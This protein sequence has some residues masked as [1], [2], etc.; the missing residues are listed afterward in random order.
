MQ[1]SLSPSRYDTDLKKAAFFDEL[2]RRVELV[3]G[4]RSAAVTM[5]LP[6]GG[7]AGTPV[8]LADQPPLKLNERPIGIIQII[9]PAYFR[10]LKIPLRRG[11]E[12]TARDGLS[13]RR[14][15]V[16]NESLAR[17]LWPAYPSGHN[18][19]GQQVLIGAKPEP[20]EVVGVVGDIHHAN[21]AIDPRPGIYRPFAQ[22]PHPFAAFVVRTEGDPLQFTNAVRNQVLAIDRDQPVS[23]VR[24]MDEVVEESVGQQ[25]LILVL[26]G[27]FA[28]V[29][30][31]L[32]VVAIY[33]VI[34]YSVAR[35]TQEVGIRLALGAQRADILLQVIGQALTLTLAGVFVGI[36]GALA[37]TRVLKTVL[38]HVTTTDPVTYGGVALTFVIIGIAASYIPARRATKVD[39]TVALR[40]E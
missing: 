21:L 2:V 37:L 18:P 40:Y 5:T 20:V 13:T 28:G 6:M 9:T 11:R 27:A 35:R 38:F 8:Q 7:F 39:P 4:V 36:A 19:V 14:V 29:A 1:I 12:F 23:Q 10:T 32:T 22:N 34:A 26:V 24:T 15:A 33:G 31:L 16:I 17:R 30:L 25:R 3:P